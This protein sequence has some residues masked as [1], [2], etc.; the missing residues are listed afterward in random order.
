MKRDSKAQHIA[1]TGVSAR[2]AFAGK[3]SWVGLRAVATLG[4]AS[5]E[6]AALY[7]WFCNRRL[8]AGEFD[9]IR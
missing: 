4:I 8:Q 6:Q 2:R 9:S 3:P 7:Q 1:K 5:S